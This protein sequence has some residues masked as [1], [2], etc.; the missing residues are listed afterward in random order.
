MTFRFIHAADIHLGYRQYNLQERH[1]DFTRAFRALVRDAIERKVDF[2]LIAGDLFHKRIIEPRTFVQAQYFLRELAEAGIPV[3]AV[4][5]N[6]ERAYYHDRFSWLDALAELGLLKTLN[7]TW[8]QG[9]IQLSP[10][11]PET[12]SGAYVDLPCGARVIGLKYYGASTGRALEALREALEALSASAPAPP[13]TILMLH[14]SPPGIIE[15]YGG[16]VTWDQLE[17]FRPLV[18]YVAMGHIHKPFSRQNWIFN[19]GSLENNS[20]A[21]AEWDERGYYV[22]QVTPD[23]D[24]LHRVTL[25]RSRR[26][27]LVRLRFSVDAIATPEVLYDLLRTYLEGNAQREWEEPPLVELVLVGVPDF[28]RREL[29]VD[30]CQEMVREIFKPLHCL[31]RD[32][33]LS[34]AYE[35]R[36]EE[37]L[38]REVLEHQVV[39]E[40]IRRD[41][42]YREVADELASVALRIKALAL[43]K[44]SPE[45]ILQELASL[46]LPTET[47]D[48]APQ[49]T[50]DEG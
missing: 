41:L 20:V 22:V 28:D 50:M 35:V 1:D 4:E 19:P 24:P 23:A 7:P 25:V 42:R 10:W 34:S 29:D 2:L 27:P 15:H 30:Y 45:D 47:T 14:A 8:D 39:A 33:T 13:Y 37:G 16:T 48:D 9:R 38:S 12:S 44:A 5:G 31:V 40:L 26:R 11:D 17:A 32:L 18:D 49:I 6:H 3:L 36:F 43:H 21:E 46:P